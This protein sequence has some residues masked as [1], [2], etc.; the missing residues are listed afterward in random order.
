MPK[1]TA[2]NVGS[3]KTAIENIKAA[4]AVGCLFVIATHDKTVA[5][6]AKT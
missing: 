3:T 6:I 1:K 2:N 5:R 4:I